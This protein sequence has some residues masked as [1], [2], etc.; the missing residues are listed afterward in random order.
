MTVAD[1][2]VSL[3]AIK[4]SLT[5]KLPA[6]KFS[7][8]LV[9][10]ANLPDADKL[11]G[12]VC[13]VNEGGGQFANYRGREGDL[14]LIDVALVGYVKVAENAEPAAVEVAELALLK[15]LLDW[16]NDQGAVR[17]GDSVLP[18]EFAQSKQLE[19]PE[20]WVVL[21]LEVRP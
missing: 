19:H 3:Q 1:P 4:D 9:D 18:M 5:A 6:R 2:N 11:A 10:P 14:G 13:I 16:T 17:A 20:G 12:F 15:D 8:S 7:R 21:K